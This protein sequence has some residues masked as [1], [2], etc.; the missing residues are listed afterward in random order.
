MRQWNEPKTRECR[1]EALEWIAVVCDPHISEM[2]ICQLAE[3]LDDWANQDTFCNVFE[4]MQLIEQSE[5]AGAD[6]ESEALERESDV[7]LISA[8]EHERYCRSLEWYYAVEDPH[9]TKDAWSRFV[10]WQRD[11]LNQA[12]FDLVADVMELSE[13][14]HWP[15]R[16]ASRAYPIA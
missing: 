14:M 12:A 16:V 3:W 1:R 2:A 6:A 11:T 13:D 5:T 9:L 15:G 10:E 8:A 4:V 7:L